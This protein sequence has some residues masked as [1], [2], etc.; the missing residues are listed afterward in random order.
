MWGHTERLVQLAAWEERHSL[1]I[2][3]SQCKHTPHM[4]PL[5]PDRCTEDKHGARRHNRNPLGQT[6]RAEPI[7]WE[8]HLIYRK[9][10]T[11]TFLIRLSS[12]KQISVGGA[13]TKKRGQTPQLLHSQQQHTPASPLVVDILS[14]SQHDKEDLKF[15][16]TGYSLF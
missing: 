3:S 6:S 7:Q 8:K 1:Q 14:F 11:E 2:R 16:H 12:A 10:Q 4:Q 13:G 9:M 5:Q 15:I